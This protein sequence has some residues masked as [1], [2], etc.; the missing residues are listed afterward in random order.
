MRNASGLGFD[1]L[2]VHVKNKKF[3]IG[4]V[5]AITVLITCGILYFVNSDDKVYD[6]TANGVWYVDTIGAP[7]TPHMFAFHDDGILHVTFPDAAEKENSAGMG[8]GVW[9]VNGENKIE[10]KFVENNADKSTNQFTTNLIVTFVVEV[11]KDNF[12]GP[13]TANYYNGVGELTQGPFP[14]T[15]KGQRIT[16]DSAP[17]VVAS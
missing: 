5:V 1:S 4:A 8:I 2:Q 12:S 17:P 15:L 3:V 16:F 6:S 13:A 10:G 11:N 9:R 14:A 7:F